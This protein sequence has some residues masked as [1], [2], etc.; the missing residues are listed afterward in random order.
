M[1]KIGIY[2]PAK[3]YGGTELLFIRLAFFLSKRDL[4][5][6]LI[7]IEGGCISN[8]DTCDG[9]NVVFTKDFDAHQYSEIILSS[10]NY[11]DFIFKYGKS[12]SGSVFIWQLHPDELCAYF[13][14]YINRLRFFNQYFFS[15]VSNLL[16]LIYR[17]RV[18]KLINLIVQLEKENKVWYMDGTS[19]TSTRKWLG[20]G[21]GDQS[22]VTF[23]PVVVNIPADGLAKNRK[24]NDKSVNALIVSR[25]TKDFKVYPI[26][27]LM[28]SLR[29]Y[30]ETHLVKISLEIVGN[31]DGVS[32][33]ENEILL[34]ST[35]LY[36][37]VKMHGFMP[38]EEVKKA[39]YPKI[40]IAFA[41]GTSALDSASYK[42]PT[43]LVPGL[44]NNV[45]ADDIRYKWLYDTSNFSLGD[46]HNSENYDGSFSK[47]ENLIDSFLKDGDAIGESCYE[48]VI[49]NHADDVVFSKIYNTLQFES[50]CI[51][52]YAEL[53]LVLNQSKITER[54]IE[55]CFLFFRFFKNIIKKY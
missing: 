39:I 12:Y 33:L 25:I 6:D 20:L 31:G 34:Y 23:M 45:N 41:M 43:V 14:P 8:L 53:E 4:S 13:F 21:N 19:Y 44:T 36:F 38:I 1:K 9:I 48:Y 18:A 27:K 46:F 47:F 5:I 37:T 16:N 54:L 52:N 42:I 40:D 17:G 15:I 10:K 32:L 7:D 35:S 2:A 50:K 49:N 26:F 3:M 28:E 29:I 11:R 24:K 51:D 22:A 55:S 30:A